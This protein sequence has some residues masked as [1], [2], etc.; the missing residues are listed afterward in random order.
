MKVVHLFVEAELPCRIAQL[1][2]KDGKKQD[3]DELARQD[4]PKLLA[5]IEGAQDAVEFYFEQVAATSAPTVPGRVAAI[6][7]VAP[8][9]RT[10]RDPLARDL[11]CDKLASLLK[12]DTGLVQRALRSAPAQQQSRM[13]DVQP[14]AAMAVA[15]EP[16]REVAQRRISLTHYS[17]LAFLA[18]HADFWP[19]VDVSI[20]KDE[21]VRAL[22]ASAQASRTFDAASLMSAC[23]AEIGDAVAKALGSDEFAGDEDANRT[24]ESIV[25]SIRFPSDLSSLMQ[26]RSAAIERGDRELTEKLN[27]RI[28][29]V[30]RSS[31]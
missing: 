11:Y 25:T 30:R 13:R 6:E 12:V 8:L 7:E 18:Q 15:A 22:V 16:V 9:L 21:Q 26:E 4:L 29:A 14:Q 2:A 23:P 5:L 10:L 27:A 28:I 1:R 17:L 31:R 24:F 20:L 3:P 19:R